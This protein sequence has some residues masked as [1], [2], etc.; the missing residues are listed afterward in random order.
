LTVNVIQVD[1]K[2]AWYRDG[3]TWSLRDADG[4]LVR[5]ATPHER[6]LIAACLAAV[7]EQLVPFQAA[8]EVILQRVR[9][10]DSPLRK[11]FTGEIVYLPS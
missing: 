2:H 4:S 10:E 9:P 6:R 1:D 5:G 11:V 3:K 7:S 8:G